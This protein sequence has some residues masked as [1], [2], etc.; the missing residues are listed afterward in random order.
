MEEA[1]ATKPTAAGASPSSTPPLP[2]PAERLIGEH[3]K[4]NIYDFGM[5]GLYHFLQANMA[6]IAA[7]DLNFTGN[8]KA[9]MLADSQNLAMK[10]ATDAADNAKA[11]QAASLDFARALNTGLA[12]AI[13][14]GGTLNQQNT[15]PVSQGEGESADAQTYP[16]NRAIDAN[17]AL[18]QGA[19]TANVA[20]V[21]AGWLAAQLQT[22]TG[23]VPVVVTA[24]GGASTPSQT[25]APAPAAS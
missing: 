10:I 14:T 13:Q 9:K 15:N 19:I 4:A 2:F 23:V 18:G 7:S 20:N 17:T 5:G 24:A 3:F 11:M 25:K 1:N 8:Y 21:L 6:A 22:A 16:P 12:T